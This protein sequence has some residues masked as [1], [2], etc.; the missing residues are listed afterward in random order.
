MHYTACYA[1]Y[2]LINNLKQKKW[3]QQT[4]KELSTLEFI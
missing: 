4:K 1:Q 2:L 3:K